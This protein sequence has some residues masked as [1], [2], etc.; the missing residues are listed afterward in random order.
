[1]EKAL[2]LDVTNSWTGTQEELLKKWYKESKAQSWKHLKASR[3]FA[4]MNN[5]LGVPVVSGVAVA[6]TASFGNIDTESKCSNNLV[7]QYIISTGLMILAILGALNTFLKYGETSERHTNAASRFKN[8]SNSIESE[9]VLP[10]DE[11]LNGKIFVK[12]A[13]KRLGELIDMCPVIPQWIDKSYNKHLKNIKTMECG[14]LDAILISDINSPKT[15]RKDDVAE[16]DNTDNS[17]SDSDSDNS[18]SNS[19][20]SN[21]TSSSN[22]SNLQAEVDQELER[23]KALDRLERIETRSVINRFNNYF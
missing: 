9:L 11:R 19:N 21:D 13:Q 14:D 4:F 1:M 18:D 15:D 7:L 16:D 22:K 23:K 12:Q 6:A 2:I 20:S 3:H 17:D 5:I 10:R 8:Y